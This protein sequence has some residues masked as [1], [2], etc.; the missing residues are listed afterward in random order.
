MLFVWTLADIKVFNN[1][2]KSNLRKY[3]SALLEE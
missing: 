1:I 2:L 3:F